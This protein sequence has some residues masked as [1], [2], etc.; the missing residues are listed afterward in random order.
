MQI[1][2]G[3]KET[4]IKIYSKNIN[5]A[6]IEQFIYTNFTNSFIKNKN[7]YIPPTTTSSLHR[8][9]LLKWLYTIYVK[10]TNSYVTDLKEILIKRAN[11]AIKIELQK[12][13]NRTIIYK[14]I[15]NNQIN[16][17]INP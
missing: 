9:F 4:I 6:N 15:N 2:L 1:L 10:N 3:S 5:I 17:S 14:I 12:P 11:K 7:I 8:S 16:I 13:I